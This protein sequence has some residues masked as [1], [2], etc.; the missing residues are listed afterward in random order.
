MGRVYQSWVNITSSPIGVNRGHHGCFISGV[1]L[2][3]LGSSISRERILSSFEA[4][5]SLKTPLLPYSIPQ[6]LLSRFGGSKSLSWGVGRPFFFRQSRKH[7]AYQRA[8]SSSSMAAG[9]CLDGLALKWFVSMAIAHFPFFWTLIQR[10]M[11]RINIWSWVKSRT[12]S[13]H[14]NPH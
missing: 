4:T 7:A 2:A 13:E 11:T 5:M 10:V 14:P 12:P 8:P 1:G 3:D 9:G 6:P